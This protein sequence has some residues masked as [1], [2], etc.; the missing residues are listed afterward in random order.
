MVLGLAAYFQLGQDEDPPFTFRA[1]VVQAYWPGASAQGR[2]RAGDRQDRAHAAGGAVLRQDPQLHQAGRVADHPAAGRLVAGRTR[3]PTPG[4]RRARRS[5]TCARTLPPGVIGPFFNDEFGDVYGSIYA[6]SADGFSDEELR[7]RAEDIR[8]Q[9][10]RVHDVA[11]VELFGVQSQKIWVELSQKRAA[12][13]GVDV[14]ARHQPAQRAERGAGLGRGRRRHAERA[15]A[16]GRRV[17]VGGRDPRAADPRRQPGHGPGHEHPAGRHRRRQARLLRSAGRQG[18]RQRQAGDRH[19]H[20]D[21]QGRRHHRARQ[22]PAGAG[23]R[24]AQAAAG[25]H[26]AARRCRTSRRRSAARWASSC[27]C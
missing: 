3:C 12:E 1:M 22:G 19:R 14:N 11:K 24:G 7:V 15:G 18:A 8:S 27:A 26:G 23:R 2:R 4:T 6:L 13:M 20:L 10:L 21:G 17:P 9:L 16:R 25:G 5:A